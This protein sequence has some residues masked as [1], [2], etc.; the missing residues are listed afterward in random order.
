MQADGESACILHVG[1]MHLATVLYNS[2]SAIESTSQSRR[3]PSHAGP[4][5]P[6]PKAQAVRLFEDR[7]IQ[8]CQIGEE[9]V[10]LAVDDLLE[11]F[12]SSECLR[13]VQLQHE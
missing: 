11:R 6:T 13:H 10:V 12:M 7:D 5:S 3:N 2:P 1:L 9:C 8:K 4:G